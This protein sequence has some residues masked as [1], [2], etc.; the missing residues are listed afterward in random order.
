MVDEGR[1]YRAI[2]RELGRS[3][4]TVMSIVQRNR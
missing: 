2:A 4:N 1:S 3:K